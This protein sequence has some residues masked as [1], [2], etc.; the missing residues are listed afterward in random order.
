MSENIFPAEPVQGTA[1]VVEENYSA[2]SISELSDLFVA[3]RAGEDAMT[4][5][6]EAE[7][8]KSAFYRLI[9]RMR[10]ENEGSPVDPQ[11]Q[12]ALENA[13]QNFKAMYADYKKDRAE[14][15]RAQDEMREANLAAKKAIIEELKALTEGQDDVSSCFPA[16]RELQNRWKEAGPVPAQSYRDINDSYQFQVEKFYDMI[17]INRDL[18]DL[19]FRKNLEAKQLLC[20]EAERLAQSEDVVAAF[21]A[22]QKLHEQWKEYGP[23]AK[24]YREAIWERFKAATAVVNKAYQAHFETL[25]ESF[26]ANLE[27]KEKLCEEVEA[28]ACREDIKDAG[29]W[30]ALSKQ[31]EEIQARWKTIGFATK[32]ANQKIYE[33]FRAACDKFYAAK[34]EYFLGIKNGMDANIAKKEALIAQA[35]QLKTST[36]WKKAT[37]QFISLQKQWKEVGAVPRKKSEQLWKRFRAACD[38]F[39]AERDKNA[40]P[41]NDFY[42]NLKAKRAL[43]A[44]I[45]QWQPSEGVSPAKAQAE[46]NERWKAIGFVPFKEKEAV[47]KEFKDAMRAAFP[48]AAAPVN[49]KNDLIRRYNALQQDI[50]TYENNIG[51]FSNSKGSAALVAQM[52]Q[53]IDNAKAELRQLE[54]QI[55]KEEAES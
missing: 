41:E 20:E 24:E 40:K 35:E 26:A 10:I 45:S 39:F 12:E 17:K 16:F 19:D 15:N 51:F 27:A 43:I 1:D 37:D 22:L 38:E 44:E 30:N 9:A 52:Q 25:K 3:L 33:R 36:D 7:A 32:S 4:R 47:A 55:R 54:E 11:A 31:I 8:I 49:R 2:K 50:I 21:A 18:R 28:I 23:V 5:Y 6:K 48:P 29:E 13:E 42:A 34:R 14:Y 46:F 53:R